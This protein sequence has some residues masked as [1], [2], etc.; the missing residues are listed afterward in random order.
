M[1]QPSLKESKTGRQSDRFSFVADLDL[2]TIA[3]ISIVAYLAAAFAHEA[4]GHGLA[5]LLVGVTPSRLTSVS[6]AWEGSN[7]LAGQERVVSAAGSLVNLLV[8]FGCLALL[9]R[10]Q[11]LGESTRYFLWLLMT[12]NFTQPGG[13][14]PMCWFFGD[15][16]SFADSFQPA[17]PWKI[18]LTL[19]GVAIY[20]GWAIRLGARELDPFLG[21]DRAARDA[22]AHRLA[23]IP[24]LSGCAVGVGAA[25]FDPGGPNMTIMAVAAY[26]G[27]TSLLCYLHLFV[28]K[29]RSLDG[30]PPSSLRPSPAW[31]LAGFL[32]LLVWIALLGPGV[33]RPHR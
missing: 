8:A 24:Y 27:G 5:C 23:L 15:W 31:L 25:L 13:Y 20:I 11:K 9:R 30:K 32:A 21:T 3:A 17:F 19:V 7:L 18:G 28:G 26:C 14:L 2:P 12:L 33:P 29:S 1:T 10:S 16:R 22:R 4:V 6:L